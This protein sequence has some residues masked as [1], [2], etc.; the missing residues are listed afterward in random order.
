MT[1]SPSKKQTSH[2]MARSANSA[3]ILELDGGILWLLLTPGTTTHSAGRFDS[4]YP[5]DGISSTRAAASGC[6]NVSSRVHS[7]RRHKE[8]ERIDKQNLRPK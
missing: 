2:K 6:D 7:S 5:A 8:R 3:H 1:S 4:L